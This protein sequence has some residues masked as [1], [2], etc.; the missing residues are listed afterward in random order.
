MELDW[1]SWLY[2]NRWFILVVA[3]EDF[4]FDFDFLV[5]VGRLGALVFV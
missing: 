4:D 3:W 1:Q 2:L 5:C